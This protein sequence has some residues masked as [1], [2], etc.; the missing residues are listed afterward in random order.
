MHLKCCAVLCYSKLVY[1]TFTLACIQSITNF[2]S[3]FFLSFSLLFSE[4]SIPYN[5]SIYVVSAR[6]F[7]F[8]SFIHQ[9]IQRMLNQGVQN[10]FLLSKSTPCAGRIK[11]S[12]S[13]CSFSADRFF[14]NADIQISLF[15]W[16]QQRETFSQFRFI[17][18]MIRP[19]RQNINSHNN[20]RKTNF[21]L[22][23]WRYI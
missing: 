6:Y 21:I 15:M 5:I 18:K 14:M 17:D 12:A 2:K 1:N 8:V 20:L 7:D 16:Q 10:A 3:I 13:F 9:K 23:Q 22:W 19:L 4:T 11:Y